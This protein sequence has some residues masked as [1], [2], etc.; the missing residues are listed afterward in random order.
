MRAKA[1]ATDVQ[2][3]DASPDPGLR[4]PLTSNRTRSISVP[5][6]STRAIS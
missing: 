1:C 6:A 2:R 3:E 4:N 5:C